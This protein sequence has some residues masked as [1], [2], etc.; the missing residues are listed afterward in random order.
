MYAAAQNFN[1]IGIAFGGVITFA[2]YNK[3]NNRILPDTLIISA[4]DDI[5]C[6][7]MAVFAFAT[8]GNLAVEHNSSI[9]TAIPDSECFLHLSCPFLH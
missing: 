1:S 2:S 3:E 6:M 4:I 7:V 5:A 8:I 9:E